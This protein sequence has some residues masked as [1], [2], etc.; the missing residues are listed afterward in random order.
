[1][2]KSANVG[3][4]DRAFRIVLGLALLILPHTASSALWADPTVGYAMN[5]V[6]VVLILTALVRFCPLYRIVGAST[7]KAS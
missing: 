2:F 7:C 1:M 3:A 4:I 5:A 6:G